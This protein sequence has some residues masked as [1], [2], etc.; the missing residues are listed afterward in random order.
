MKKI[1]VT[2]G[3]G[4]IGSHLVEALIKRGYKVKA[5]IRYNSMRS[6]GNLR[7]AEQKLLKHAQLIFGNIEDVD[8]IKKISKD[9]DVVMH[10]AALIGIPYSYDAVRSYINT[11][12]IGTQNILQAGLNNRIKQI[13][14]TSTSETYGSA[15]YT[16]MDE[17]HPLKGQSPYSATK[18]AADKL[19][20]SYY[21]SFDL[22]VSVI[23]PFNTYGPRQSGRAVI[24]AIIMQLLQKRRS[25]GIGSEFPVRDFSYVDDTVK[26]FISMIGNKGSIGEVI[27]VGSGEGISIR[28]LTRAICGLLGRSRTRACSMNE[29][30]RPEK[31]EVNC[32]VCDNSKAKRIL[33]WSPRVKLHRGLE[34]V[35]SFME[36]NIKLYQQKDYIK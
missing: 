15:E 29:R 16:P 13:I 14:H 22:P 20:E 23:R 21:R 11:N 7:F 2:G 10:L 5:L 1:L 8:F 12:I 4:F 24:P 19:A 6:I 36:K 30:R 9:V 28:E 3:A 35:I 34:K 18:I 32:L 27:N 17:E 26:A 25:I 31:S 33:S